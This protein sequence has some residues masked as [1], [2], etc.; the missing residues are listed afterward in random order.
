MAKSDGSDQLILFGHV[1]A[2]FQFIEEAIRIYLKTVYALI[3]RKMRGEIPVK[4]SAKNL[5]RKSL[6]ALLQE[7]EKLT[8]HNELAENI[9]TLIPKRNHM[10]HVA[11]YK[12]YQQ[13]VEEKDD[14][15]DMQEAREIG[16]AANRCIEVLHEKI[17]MVERLCLKAGIAPEEIG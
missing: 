2:K 6:S 3:K 15:D 13:L 14:T 16:E 11:F 5:E 7:F 17:E 8:G 9:R 4:L 12:M 1:L 10:A